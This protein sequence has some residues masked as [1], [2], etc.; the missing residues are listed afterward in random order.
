MA[1]EGAAGRE[2]ALRALVAASAAVVAAALA[3]GLFPDR[4][5]L[6]ELTIV[7]AMGQ[8][9][10]AGLAAPRFWRGGWSEAIFGAGGRFLL[11]LGAVAFGAVEALAVGRALHGEAPRGAL[12]LLAPPVLVA[13]F[14]LRGAVTHREEGRDTDGVEQRERGRGEA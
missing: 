7:L 5:W 14:A 8:G 6:V 2:A 13:A 4:A 11:F 1:E 10:L 12:L 9:T 3:A